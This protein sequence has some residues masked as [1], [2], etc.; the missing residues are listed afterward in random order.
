MEAIVTAHLNPSL[1]MHAALCP[2]FGRLEFED[3]D[4]PCLCM[5]IS[6]SLVHER[7]SEIPPPST[8]TSGGE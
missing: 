5:Q 2:R 4:L 1:V 6:A 7:M 8:A 3:R